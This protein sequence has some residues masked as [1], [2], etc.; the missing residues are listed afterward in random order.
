MNNI[1]EIKETI[2]IFG[3]SKYHINIEIFQIL[4]KRHN[5]NY[6][7]YRDKYFDQS[8]NYSI[9]EL[10]NELVNEIVNYTKTV[11]NETHYWN[12]SI[13][14][15]YNDYF[16]FMLVVKKGS[17]E[18]ITNE[19]SLKNIVD[20]HRFIT[21]YNENHDSDDK[22]FFLKQF[23]TISLGSNDVRMKIYDGDIFMTWD[24]YKHETNTYIAR[25][26][27]GYIHDRPYYKELLWSD[28]YGFYTPN[29]VLNED[30]GRIIF[31]EGNLNVDDKFYNDYCLKLKSKVLKIGNL[32]YDNKCLKTK[33]I[34][35]NEPI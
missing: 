12:E 21:I 33:I 17:G 6:R 10:P 35:P 27:D 18:I 32:Y 2:R 24:K 5:L 8:V 25:C 20:I 7:D 31:E 13:F 11:D 26:R 19:V 14:P 23:D 16:N 9:S 15:D 3:R 34:I 30:K 29:N 1:D 28:K 4:C 22:I